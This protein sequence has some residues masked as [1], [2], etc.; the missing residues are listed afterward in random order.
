MS[1]LKDFKNQ[2]LAKKKGSANEEKTTQT[3]KKKNPIRVANFSEETKDEFRN[4]IPLL[5]KKIH[6]DKRN[7]VD[8]LDFAGESDY[9]SSHQIFLRAQCGY[10]LVLNMAEDLDSSPPRTISHS[11]MYKEWTNRGKY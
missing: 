7:T 9:Y 10:I 4:I 6:N 2:R 5:S 8:I 1:V 3:T 11:M